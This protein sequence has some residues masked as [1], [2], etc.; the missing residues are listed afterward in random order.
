MISP[1]NYPISPCVSFNLLGLFVKLLD[2]M[3]AM[4]ATA[5]QIKK[6]IQEEDWQKH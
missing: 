3:T 5:A 6:A 1:A 2:Q 4:G